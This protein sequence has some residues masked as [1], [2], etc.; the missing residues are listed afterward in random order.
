MVSLN[1]LYSSKSYLPLSSLFLD[2]EQRHLAA[3]GEAGTV[4]AYRS[5]QIGNV[6]TGTRRVAQEITLCKRF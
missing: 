1:S 4:W 3:H 6:L 5:L 2:S